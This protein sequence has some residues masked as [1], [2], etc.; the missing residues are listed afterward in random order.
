MKF[1]K[2]VQHLNS[3]FYAIF[4]PKTLSVNELVFIYYFKIH[5]HGL[6]PAVKK[7]YNVISLLRAKARQLR[8]T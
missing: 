6:K 1:V 7:S 3:F 2:F 4:V 8:V 5:P